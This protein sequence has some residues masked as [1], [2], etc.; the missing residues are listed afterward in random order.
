MLALQ[1]VALA[2]CRYHGTMTININDPV[3]TGI[4]HVT[5][6]D[7]KRGLPAGNTVPVALNDYVLCLATRHACILLISNFTILGCEYSV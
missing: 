2:W 6:H 5:V 3:E 7:I 4:R 1:Y